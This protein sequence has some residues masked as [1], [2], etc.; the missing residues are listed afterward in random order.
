MASRSTWCCRA[1]SS[2]PGSAPKPGAA[3][4]LTGR[5]SSSWP[6]SPRASRWAAWGSR[7]NSVTWSRSWLPSRPRTLPAPFTR[8]TGATSS[9]TS[10]APRPPIGAF[11]LLTV[12]VASLF[13]LV[14][15]RNRLLQFGRQLTVQ[16]RHLLQRPLGERQYLLPFRAARIVGGRLNPHQARV[17]VPLGVRT[18]RDGIERQ[19]FRRLPGVLK[20]RAGGGDVRPQKGGLEGVQ[21]RDQVLPRRVLRPGVP[22]TILLQADLRRRGCRRGPAGPG[23]CRGAAAA[24]STGRQREPGGERRA[25]QDGLVWHRRVLLPGNRAIIPSVTPA[26]PDI[27][28]T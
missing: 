9:P 14:Q 18:F 10:S 2:P 16:H 8:S 19:H 7:P 28:P 27:W 20:G 12:P 15:T 24:R 6:P 23:G 11:R 25:G 21:R 1:C 4:R 22:R 17:P 13:V 5:S 26:L 3:R